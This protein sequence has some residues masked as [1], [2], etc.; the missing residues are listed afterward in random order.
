[1]ELINLRTNTI[2][3][4]FNGKITVSYII[5]SHLQYTLCD[6]NKLYC[7]YIAN[8]FVEGNNILYKESSYYYTAQCAIYLTVIL[9][10]NVID[11]L[12][13][14]QRLCLQCS[15]IHFLIFMIKPATVNQFLIFMIKPA[16]VNQFLIFMIKPATVNLFLSLKNHY[17]SQQKNIFNGEDVIQTY[18]KSFRSSL[19]SHSLWVTL[20]HKKI[21]ILDFWNVP[22]ESIQY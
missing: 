7:R 20:Y 9:S 3:F 4:T 11:Y 8:A 21:L 18:L 1:M 19:Q 2:P 17:I 15:V 10:L 5:H 12:L 13:E 6:I 14:Q 22:K 16:T